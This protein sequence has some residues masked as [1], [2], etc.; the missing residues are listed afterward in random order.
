[1]LMERDIEE[2]N[3]FITAHANAAELLFGKTDDDTVTWE[4]DE[5][6]SRLAQEQV[7]LWKAGF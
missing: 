2:E 6:C 7:D 1:M 3:V 5:E 4:Q